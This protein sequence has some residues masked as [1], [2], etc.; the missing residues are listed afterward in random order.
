VA[1]AIKIRGGSVL[2]CGRRALD[3]NQSPSAGRVD[4]HHLGHYVGRHVC[5]H[6]HDFRVADVVLCHRVEDVRQNPSAVRVGGH[7]GA[8]HPHDFRAVD[9]ALCHLA[10]DVRQNLNEV[11]ADGHRGDHHVVDEH[12][13]LNAVRVVG[14]H[15]AHHVGRHP[16][17]L[18]VNPH[19]HAPTVVC[20]ALRGCCDFVHAQGRDWCCLHLCWSLMRHVY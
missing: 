1:H 8:H 7:R 2:L 11:C 18:G 16:H 13:N 9:A 19:P 12:R 3:A 10:A 4:G 20:S 14:H 6:P 15:D 5:H 17:V